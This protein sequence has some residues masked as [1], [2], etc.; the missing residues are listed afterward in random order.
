MSE[1]PTSIR[2]ELGNA[3]IRAALCLFL[4]ASVIG[5]SS[6]AERTNAQSQERLKQFLERF[7]E[8]DAN[9][10]GALTMEEVRAYRANNQTDRTNRPQTDRDRAKKTDEPGQ[11]AKR[12]AK[13]PPTYADVPYGP[14]KATALDFWKA[15][16]AAAPAPLFVFIHGG[17]FRGGDKASFTPALLQGCLDAGFACASINYRLSGEAIY[18]AQMHDSARAIQFLRSKAKEWNIDP[19][20]VAAGGG[21][22]GSGISQWLGFH[23]DLADPKSDDPVARRS[24]RVCAVLALNMQCTYDPR[25]IMEIIPGNA[26]ENSALV[27]LFG[28]PDD[29]DW[30]RSKI[31]KDLDAGLKDVSPITHLTRDDAPVFAFHNAKADVPG[32]IHHAN[33]GR[34]LKKAMD[35]I[36]VECVH[37]M[38]TDFDPP[39]EQYKAMVSFLK[40]HFAKDSLN[41]E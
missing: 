15:K 31:D 1:K 6:A 40:K 12:P 5:V 28:L 38:D 17:G 19:K 21:S 33:F 4:V 25:V 8:A 7:P 34:H 32:N 37:K 36:G 22:A 39:A 3:I 41:H 11:R 9:G 29:W 27:K 16:N 24:T 2:F 14:H 35:K 30:K 26:Y 18:P 20:R 10:D 13:I 23:E